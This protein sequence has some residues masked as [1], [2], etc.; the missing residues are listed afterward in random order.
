MCHMQ[1]VSGIMIDQHFILSQEK[2]RE[3]EFTQLVVFHCKQSHI[4][5]YKTKPS[6][7][8]TIKLTPSYI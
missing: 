4:L 8:F 3:K 7:F 6:S 2:K 5:N 1:F